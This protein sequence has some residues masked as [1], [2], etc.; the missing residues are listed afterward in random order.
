MPSSPISRS[1][2]HWISALP[3]VTIE[4]GLASATE[5]YDAGGRLVCAGLVETHV[6]LDKSRIIDRCPSE[7]ARK[8]S[9]MRQVATK[10][11]FTAT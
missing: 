5:S 1:R 6:H 2:S 8:T 3:I 4:H 10:P 9:P 11:S 7:A